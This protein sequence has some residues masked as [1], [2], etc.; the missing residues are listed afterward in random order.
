[1]N[2]SVWILT[3]E[4]NEYDQYG[5]YFIKVFF[6]KPTIEELNLLKLDY[7]DANF[8]LSKGGG[9]KKWEDAWYFLREH[10]N[11]V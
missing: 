7:L 9:R 10:F 6:K 11:G 1:M 2:N 3:E 8:L 4:R 5:E